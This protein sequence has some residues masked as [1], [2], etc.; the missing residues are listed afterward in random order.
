MEQVRLMGALKL[1]ATFTVTLA[2]AAD[3]TAA[4]VPGEDS[5]KLEIAMGMAEDA[6]S[7]Y[8]ESPW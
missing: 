1:L 8:V 5:A 3:P 4:V 2:S 7:V 6:D